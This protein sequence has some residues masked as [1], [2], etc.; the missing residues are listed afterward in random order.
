[1]CSILLSAALTTVWTQSGRLPFGGD[2]PHYVI[3]SVSVA[4]DLDLELR[5]N[6]WW[7]A[8]T[9]EVFGPVNA[10]VLLTTK[11]WSPIHTPGLGVLLAAP[12]SL[13]GVLGARVALSA[14]AL[15]LLAMGCWRHMRDSI[16]P[17][18]ARF[19]VLGI[20]ACVATIFGGSQV[21][22]DLQCGAI[23][24]ALVT[25]VWSPARRTLPG[26]A[27]YWLVAGL[28]PWLHTKYFA[29]A[30]LLAA[31]GAW[32]A[33]RDQR[34]PA[35]ALSVLFA[36]GSGSLMWW[37]LQ[38]FGGVLGWRRLA[39]LGTDP[40]RVLEV[41][42]GLHLDQA[43]GMFFQQ[44]LLLA[45]LIGL[46]HMVGRRH[47]LTVPWLLLYGSLIGPNSMELNWYGGGGPAGR[48]AW[49]AMWLWIIPLGIWLKDERAALERYVRPIVLG[50]LAYQAALAMQWVPAPSTLF[51][52]YSELLWERNSLFPVDLRHFVPSFYFWDFETYLSHPPNIVWVT[53]AVLLAVTG[54]LWNSR[55]GIDYRPAGCWPWS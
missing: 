17:Q 41:F 45:G 7:D 6:Y 19:A 37:H 25:W 52:V 54:L 44:P 49:S 2:E 33:R 11:G 26:W 4:R 46:G 22:P 23:V 18:A 29:T 12:W 39:D 50:G 15:S 5:N 24:L 3:M 35:L 38:T 27:G 43:Q 21:Y 16:S 42:L 13:A 10:H 20:I 1:M 48:F 53:A 34:R 47:P 40:L 36:A 9:Q 30:V 28:L 51:P 8:R 32:Q 31:V 55:R 14:I